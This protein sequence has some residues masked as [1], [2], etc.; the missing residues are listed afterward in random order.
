MAIGTTVKVG[1]DAAAVRSGMGG[2]KGLFAGTMRG[3][4]QVGIGV[5]RQAGVNIM[6]ILGN[7][8]MAGP[9]LAEYAGDMVD[10]AARTRVSVADL[11]VLEEALEL[12]GAKGADTSRMLQ[13]LADNL[14]EATQNIGPARDALNKLGFTGAEFVK[15]P[16]DK[17]FEKIGRKVGT[18]PDDFEGLEG[19]MSDLFGARGGFRMISF[20]RDFDGGM[21][22]ARANAEPFAKDL[23]ENAV[24][25]DELS[26]QASAWKYA[27]QS[28]VL[29]GMKTMPAI[30]DAGFKDL[31]FFDTSKHQEFWKGLGDSVVSGIKAIK[32]G[33]LP[34]IMNDLFLAAGAKMGEGFKAALGISS[35]SEG[36]GGG[37]GG[38]LK[39]AFKGMFG[40]GSPTASTGGRSLDELIAQ[41]TEQTSYLRRI[42][43]KKGGWA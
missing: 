30:L 16:I 19:I 26:E 3:F 11:V 12:A 14:Y 2:L 24:A 22:Q 27:W 17:A 35:S 13:M 1:W 15:L 32:N 38:M 6:E 10:F 34:S 4:R 21:K 43:E 40:G 7:A 9:K 23:G 41:G 25:L 31:G 42:A 39:G 8:L 33:E 29:Q 18:L 20:F 28:F 37:M 5:A 36:G